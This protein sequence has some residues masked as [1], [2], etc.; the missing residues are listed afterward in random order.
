MNLHTDVP[1]PALLPRLAE[2]AA[3]LAARA[4]ATAAAGVAGERR[5]DFKPTARG[6]PAG[7]NPVSDLDRAIEESLRASIAAEWPG[8]AIVGEELPAEAGGEF[9]WVLDPI[10][11][12]T[13]FLNGLP[14]F[15]VSI[16]VLHRWRP[17]AGAIWCSTSHALRAGTYHGHVGDCL[18]FD[19]DP[20]E[21]RREGEW[22]G[23]AT[24]PGRAP[25]LGLHWDTRVLGSSAIECAFAAAGLLAVASLGG[26][27]AWDVAAGIALVRAAGGEAWERRADGW[28]PFERFADSAD[29][30]RA[31][32]GWR[33]PLLLG[34]RDAV[35]RATTASP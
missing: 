2:S 7:S 12:T 17:V 28:H 21:P 23:L 1:D 9:A 26:P 30:A 4:G 35:Y 5:V 18:R 6:A 22:R 15:A 16:G 13:N 20:V 33:R 10:D 34:A 19:G 29:D 25:A 31:V 14:V 8:H 27:R 11:G 3:R 32:H 24:E